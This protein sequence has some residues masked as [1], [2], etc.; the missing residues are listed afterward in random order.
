[1]ELPVTADHGWGNRGWLMLLDSVC[2]HGRRAKLTG[3]AALL[4]NV[5]EL[6]NTDFLDKEA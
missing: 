2:G 1:M 3:L 6:R 5:A 4:L